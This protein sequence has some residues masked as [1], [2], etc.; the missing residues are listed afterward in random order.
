MRR[1]VAVLRHRSETTT[2]EITV[3]LGLDRH[4]AKTVWGLLTR[5][6]GTILAHTLTRLALV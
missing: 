6:A 1:P 5:T 4:G 2:G 3:A